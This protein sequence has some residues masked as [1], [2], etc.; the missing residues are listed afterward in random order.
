MITL[1]V[2]IWDPHSTITSF[3]FKRFV[4]FLFFVFLRGEGG[5]HTLI[6]LYLVRL[7]SCAILPRD[8]LQCSPTWI[9]FNLVLAMPLPLVTGKTDRRTK[10][11]GHIDASPGAS[12][13]P[14]LIEDDKHN[15]YLLCSSSTVLYTEYKSRPI[16]FFFFF[17]A[18]YSLFA[19]GFQSRRKNDL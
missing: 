3:Y 14:L 17:H 13:R 7:T 16:K 5:G 19:N 10:Q 11:K 12:S 18:I 8:A 9:V 4:V 2:R 15:Q 6:A 1:P